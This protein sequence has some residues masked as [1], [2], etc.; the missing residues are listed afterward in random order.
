[1][2]WR[3]PP[4]AEVCSRTRAQVRASH[5]KRP[6]E[7]DGAA[8][9][10][11]GSQEDDRPDPI[12]LSL[13][14]RP[15]KPIC[16]DLRLARDRLPHR[17]PVPHRREV[18][19]VDLH[20]AGRIERAGSKTLDERFRL[21]FDPDR[22]LASSFHKRKY[23]LTNSSQSGRGPFAANRFLLLTNSAA[24]DKRRGRRAIG[25]IGRQRGMD[26]R[27]SRNSRGV[28]RFEPGP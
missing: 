1:M 8:L 14:A 28:K 2:G 9:E 22:P 18:A 15:S 19:G 10:R 3:A 24:Q 12:P 5:E 21:R 4:G 16:F 23:L 26:P 17:S 11:A 13:S 6:A 20:P 7:I 27:A 25:P